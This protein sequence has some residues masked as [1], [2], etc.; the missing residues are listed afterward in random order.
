MRILLA[1]SNS[2][3][4]ESLEK[5]LIQAKNTVDTTID[6]YEAIVLGSLPQ[7]SGADFCHRIRTAHIKTPILLLTHANNEV[8]AIECLDYGADD[9]LVRPYS[10]NELMARL[11][12]LTRRAQNFTTTTISTGGL[13]IDYGNEVLLLDGTAI[14][15]RPSE[16]S[17]LEY[18]MRTPGKVI[19]KEELLQN[20]WS[21]SAQNASN[22]LEVCMFNIRSKLES[23]SQ[24][25]L[26]R[27]IRGHGY[28]VSPNSD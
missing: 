2:Q 4:A 23:V 18:L 16:Y 15:L 27:T 3:S 19:H 5:S 1:D 28:V 21:I 22:R 12:A 11:R 7:M 20:V 9:Y 10:Y 6:G 25:Q 13:V 14:K 8:G 24:K 26:L 17:L